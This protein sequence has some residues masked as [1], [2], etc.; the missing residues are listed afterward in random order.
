[1][2]MKDVKNE[3]KKEFLLFVIN[4]WNYNKKITIETL[5]Y[6][7]GISYYHIVGCDLKSKIKEVNNRIKESQQLQRIN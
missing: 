3:M 6:I 5:S 2:K 1:M 4:N 7:T